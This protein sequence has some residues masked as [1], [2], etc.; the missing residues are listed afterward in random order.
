M[1]VLAD[2]STSPASCNWV[3]TLFVA[4]NV[5]E[6]PPAALAIL[7]MSWLLIALTRLRAAMAVLP[8]ELLARSAP[9]AAAPIRSPLF[10]LSTIFNVLPASAKEMP[11]PI[12]VPA[13]N[14]PKLGSDSKEVTT[15]IT[16]PSSTALMTFKPVDTSLIPA[17]P[18][19]DAMPP[20]MSP[21]SMAIAA[22]MA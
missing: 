3:T 5:L 21:L 10:K 19:N 7:V 14:L 15:P 4:L 17:T 12:I 6:K 22:L 9:V 16:L 1:L 18:A 8:S 11:S 13:A 20:K 2:L